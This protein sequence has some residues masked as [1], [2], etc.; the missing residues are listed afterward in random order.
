LRHLGDL[1]VGFTECFFAL[2][3]FGYIKKEARFL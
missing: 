3:V 1:G 2:F